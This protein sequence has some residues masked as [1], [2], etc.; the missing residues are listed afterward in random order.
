MKA[1]TQAVQP[2]KR[3]PLYDLHVEEGARIVPFAGWEMPIQYETG[4]REEHLCVRKG[5]GIFDVSHMG[6]LTVS[7]PGSLTLLQHLVPRNLSTLK[8][9]QLAYTV[10]CRSNG[11]VLDDLA[12]YRLGE[13]EYLLVVNASR[14]DEDFEWLEAQAGPVPAVDVSR[15]GDRGM[16]AL[17]G[18]RAEEIATSLLAKELSDL[19]YY[20]FVEVTYNGAAIVVSRSGY[21][22][23]DGFEIICQSEHLASLWRELRLAG[24]VAAGLGARDTLR[25]E[26]GYC[27]YGQELSTE[28]TPIEAG[29]EWTMALD[30]KED[31]V[32]RT[33]LRSQLAAGPQRRLSGLIALDRGIPRPGSSVVSESTGRV[34]RISSGTFSPTLEKGIA[35]AFIDVPF[36]ESGTHLELEMRGRLWPVQVRSLPLVPSRVKRLRN[37]SRS[38]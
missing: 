37:R 32:G 36:D 24:A 5:V 30:K 16:L 34:G 3:T 4:I 17:Q 15:L 33:A 19:R 13:D 10:L 7:G 22:G 35:L 31:F 6:Q 25:T 29:L 9:G 2:P 11:G 28:T 12:V 8:V 20:H 18:P 21:T 14:V 26:M 27:L 1:A 23:E 38:E